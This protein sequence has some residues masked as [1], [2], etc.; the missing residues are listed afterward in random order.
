[1]NREKIS[2]AILLIGLIL[3]TG[4]ITQQSVQST[5]A[6]AVTTPPTSPVDNIADRIA[7]VGDIVT[8]NY[9][10]ILEDGAVFDTSDKDVAL[11]TSVP[12][13]GGFQIKED[14]F[15]LTFKLGAGK[16]I[17]GFEEAIFGMKVGDVKPVTIPPE[18]AYG[19]LTEDQ[20]TYAPRSFTISRYENITNAEFHAKLK[21]EPVKGERV[22]LTDLY[23]GD[24]I[25]RWDDATVYDIDWKGA[26]V[27]LYHEPNQGSIVKIPI[28]IIQIS[29]TDDSITQT[30]TPEINK[31]AFTKSGEYVTVLGYDDQQVKTAYTLAG[32]TLVFK[33]KL[34][35]IS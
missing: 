11:D 13:I 18:K 27:T 26:M 34:E 7:K 29:I 20:I 10:G 16:V 23:W 12:K 22:Y 35:K 31:T 33:I 6:P 2:I 28:G 15:P 14:Y 9:I 24:S 32:K 19:P 21:T 1:M 5:D 8:V 4:C 30:L 25:R 3:L 17:K